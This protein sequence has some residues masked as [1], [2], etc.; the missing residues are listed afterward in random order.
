MGR[1]NLL[2]EPW[3]SVFVKTGE[4]KEVSMMDFFKESNGFLAMAGEM[5]TQN[6]AIL[7]FLLSVVQTVFSAGRGSCRLT[8]VIF[9]PY[10]RPW[11]PSCS[12]P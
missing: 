12:R 4:K 2:D 10:L 11:L 1:F 6:F 9:P 3:I 5:E 7:R 8:A